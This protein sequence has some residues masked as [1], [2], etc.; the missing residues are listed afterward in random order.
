MQDL[1][2]YSATLPWIVDRYCDLLKLLFCFAV[3]V[4]ASIVRVGVAF[5]AAPPV[6]ALTRSMQL[7]LSWPVLLQKLCLLV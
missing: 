7:T 4:S 3:V 5:I 6:L 2:E 1:L